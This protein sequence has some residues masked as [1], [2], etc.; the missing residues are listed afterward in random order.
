MLSRPCFGVA[1]TPTE[2]TAVGADAGLRNH[3]F[4]PRYQIAVQSPC[5]PATAYCWPVEARAPTSLTPVVL[6][7]LAPCRPTSRT[8]GASGLGAEY[9]RTA[10]EPCAGQV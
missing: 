2:L 7:P 4:C 9:S 8:S 6:A 1:T 5:R 10:S 3:A